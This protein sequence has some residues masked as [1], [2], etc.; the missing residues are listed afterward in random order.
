MEASNAPTLYI[1]FTPASPSN[2]EADFSFVADQ[3]KSIHVD[4]RF[5]SIQLQPGESLWD[6][7]SPWVTSCGIAGWSYILTAEVLANRIRREELISAIENVI[8]ERGARFP[9]LG[10]LYHGIA[11]RNLPLA[12]RLRPCIHLADQNWKEQ[13]Q[14]VLARQAAAD[15]SEFSWAIHKDYSGVA[16]KT[17]IEVR[18]RSE[19]I[20]C[21]RFAVPKTARPV[22]WGCGAPRG[23]EI[24]PVLFSTVRGAGRLENTEISWFGCEDSLSQTVSAYV[25]FDGQLPDFVCFGRAR[26]P[27]SAP[28]K[29]EIF[30][31]PRE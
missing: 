9:L 8:Q 29:M 10:M 15:T 5:E 26:S 18:P 17:A 21:W 20:N 24:S 28:G 4:A 23:G 14:A 11:A 7:I 2:R 19:V 12:L 13:V 30:R 3:L 31:P 27:V 22:R 16:A 6:R 1:C 25:V